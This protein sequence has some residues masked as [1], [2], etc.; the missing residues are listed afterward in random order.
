MVSGRNTTAAQKAKPSTLAK[1]TRPKTSSTNSNKIK[2]KRERTPEKQDL[3]D[4]QNEE[5]SSQKSVIFQRNVPKL[6]RAKD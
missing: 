4:D 2:K 3:S 5:P 1:G 6:K